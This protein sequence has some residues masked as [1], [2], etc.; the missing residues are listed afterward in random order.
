[1]LFN[2]VA[3]TGAFNNVV[4]PALPIGLIWNTSNLNSTGTI[5]VV[6]NTTPVIG[7]IS[8]SGGS[9]GLSGTGG[10][11][12]ANFVLL[13][14]T[15]LSTPGSDWTRLLTN[16]FDSSGNFNFTTNAATAG[17][18]NFYRLLLGP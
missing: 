7:A 9:L 5:A 13:G 1:V 11:G 8:I 3:Y 18:Q 15:N 6:L 17:P 14:A 16:Q 12:S 2:A 10:V 4:L